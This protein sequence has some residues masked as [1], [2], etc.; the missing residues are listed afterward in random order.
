MSVLPTFAD[1]PIASPLLV[2]GG[3][4]RDALTLSEITGFTLLH[5]RGA[6][7]EML[8]PQYG[9]KIGG[10]AS[11]DEG[12]LARLRRDE[13]VLLSSQ[14]KSALS[15]LEERINNRSIT[16]TD[17]THGRCMLLLVGQDA[18]SVLS[19]LCALDFSDSAFSG[20]H[21]AQTSLAKVRALIIGSDTSPRQTY[22][23]IVDRSLGQYVWDIVIDAMQ[24]F[25]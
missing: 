1:L 24:E 10:V 22:Y 12:M 9:M 8:L 13:F 23:L 2:Q 18:T 3:G 7:A 6:D 14:G 20:T 15:R 16:L 25:I 5:I 21:A 19:R 4:K 11:T 17:L